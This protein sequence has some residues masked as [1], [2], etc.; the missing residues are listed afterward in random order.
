MRVSDPLRILVFSP[1]LQTLGIIRMDLELDLCITLEDLR[2]QS[3][4]S[5]VN[6]FCPFAGQEAAQEAGIAFSDLAPGLRSPTSASS[7]AH[8][9]SRPGEHLQLRPPEREVNI[10]VPIEQVALKYSSHSISPPRLLSRQPVLLH[11]RFVFVD[12]LILQL[13]DMFFQS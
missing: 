10:T 3:C 4:K 7:H 1:F 5:T 2:K 12:I 13:L 9:H 11:L 6:P 8:E